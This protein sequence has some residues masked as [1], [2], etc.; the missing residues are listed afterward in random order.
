L[1]DEFADL[2]GITQTEVES[3][4]KP[5][6]QKAQEK[7]QI[8]EA[9]L[10]S[11]IKTWYN[12]YSWDGSTRVYNPWS[13]M[14]F[15][16]TQTFR[17]FWFETGTPTFLLKQITKFKEFEFEELEVNEW[18]FTGYGIG[19]IKWLPLLF[20]LGYLTILDRNE[21]GL[22]RLGIPNQEVRLSI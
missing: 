13:L 17:N 6:L 20:Q 8:S 2:V 7:F 12:G 9:V 5:Y 16:S 1:D 11:K 10:L 22:Y 4:F 18:A 15:L 14:S 3:Q 19:N 21:F